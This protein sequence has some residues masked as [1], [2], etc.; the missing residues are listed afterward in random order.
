MHDSV[1]LFIIQE[2][3]FTRT[4]FVL[5][6]YMHCGCPGCLQGVT[7]PLA[8]GLARALRGPRGSM[9]KTIII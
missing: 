8:L 6:R 2:T 9:N 3:T 4:T 1:K 5:A 7:G